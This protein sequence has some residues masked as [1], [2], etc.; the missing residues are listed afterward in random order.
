ML[1]RRETKFFVR[2]L[3]DYSV[4]IFSFSDIKRGNKIKILEFS[5][6]LRNQRTLRY[7]KKFFIII[8]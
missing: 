8:V 4:L 7:K 1:L 2:S 3:R 5:K 6:T